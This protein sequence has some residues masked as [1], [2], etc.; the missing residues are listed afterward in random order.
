MIGL[1]FAA[2]LAVSAPA[3]EQGVKLACF[4]GLNDAETPAAL[5]DCESPDL[6]NTESNLNGSAILK[7]K[8]FSKVADLSIAT[9]PVTGSHSFIDSSG[10]R[11]DIVC[12]DKNCSA[13][14]N[15]NAFS[16]FYST[17]GGTGAAPT[18]WSWVDVGGVAYGANNRYDKILAYDGT[19]TS[20][21]V[22]MPQGSI[23]ELEQSRLVVGDISGSPNRVHHSSAGAVTQF[24]IG[25]NSQDSWY[26]EIG[27]PGD[28]IRGL[29]YINGNLYIFKTASITICQIADQYTS[30]CSVLSPNIG[31]T[32]PGSIVAA[33]SFIYFRAQ[34]KNYW[35]LGPNGLRQISKKIPNLVRSQSGG[36]QG[37]EQSNT[38]TTQADWQ[39]GTQRPLSSWNTTTIPGSIFPSSAT[40]VDTSS[41]DWVSGTLVYLTTESVP[42][43]IVMSSSAYRDD[44]ATGSYTTGRTTWTKTSG[45]LIAD[46]RGLVSAGNGTNVAHSTQINLST[47]NWSFSYKYSENTAE[48]NTCI[49]SAGTP[50][51][52]VRFFKKTNG[53][54]YALEVSPAG[55]SFSH[56]VSIVKS[57]S[58]VRT[59]LSNGTLSISNGQ[60]VAFNVNRS[61]DGRIQA[62]ADGVFIASTSADTSVTAA[63]A[64][65]TE[66]LL[67]EL[68][69]SKVWT[70]FISN[71]YAYA[72]P[73]TATFYSRVYDTAYSTPVWGTFQ[74]TYT[75]RNDINEGNIAFYTQSSADGVT[76]NPVVSTSDTLRPSTMTPKRYFRYVAQFQ[77]FVT[78][79]TPVLSDAGLLVATTGQFISQCIQPNASITSWGTLS[80]AETKAGVGSLVYYATSAATCASLPVSTA[81]VNFAG[82]AQAGWVQQ[83]NNATLTISTNAAVFIGFRSLLGSA[84][85]QAQVDACTLVWVESGTVQSAWGVYDSVKNSLY[86]TTTINGAA[87]TNRL[88]K[89]DRNLEQWYPFDI[90]ALAP[91]MINNT[92]YFGGA[93]S[94]TWN[95]YGS[96][97]S[98]AGN[99]IRAYWKSN[100]IGNDDPFREK[101][102]KTLSILSRNNQAGSMTGTWTLSNA[103]TG[104]YTI[105]LSTSSGVSYARSNYFLPLAS[106]QQFIN[107]QVG[108]NNSTPFE[109]LGLG[110][111]W[112]VKPWR[113]SGP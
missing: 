95:S 109:V 64:Y 71:F 41:S 79:K 76:F 69:T 26:D 57:V 15:G 32:D 87:T 66:L 5:G 34:D 82:A 53:D 36:L 56:T 85:D 91:K 78:T 113:P 58:S 51:I 84:T 7:R 94:G 2:F 77:T 80:C 35:E 93:S 46:S 70:Q 96:V 27:A 68:D 18:R 75:A 86:W 22:G 19:S 10:N 20:N 38:Q 6:L 17:A 50:C 23:L 31:T 39:N 81:P 16:T 67:E 106:P 59:F 40:F 12:Q 103:Q 1:L 11:K 49:Q 110:V 83:T 3:Q 25:T 45:A 62:T 8:G 111:T 21:P 102:F 60:T 101:Q 54:Y 63:G 52:S 107:V 104:S 61:T 72:Y 97:D 74:A 73:S 9:S 44:W 92:M 14:T 48:V 90:P 29:K 99:P 108:N 98:D 55:G 105:S 4:A 42:G 24:T 33:G 28:R 112:D 43:S 30:Y 47:G 13:S 37:G 65:Y 89:F 100:D 88:L